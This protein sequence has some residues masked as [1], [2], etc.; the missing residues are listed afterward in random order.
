M[1]RND[2]IAALWLCSNEDLQEFESCLER[3]GEK[4]AAQYI[5]DS[6]SSIGEAKLTD[7]KFV[8][9]PEFEAAS[10]EWN[11]GSPLYWSDILPSIAA[12]VR[13]HRIDAT[14]IIEELKSGV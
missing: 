12:F 4:L 11:N 5:R 9:S 1:W 10:K 13:K 2:G 8:L 7:G 14:E 6:I 3:I